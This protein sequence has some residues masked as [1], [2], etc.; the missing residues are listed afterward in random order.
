MV[1]EVISLLLVAVVLVGDAACLGQAQPI[2]LSRK[3]ILLTACWARWSSRCRQHL[4]GGYLLAEHVI[5]CQGVGFDIV[6]KQTPHSGFRGEP[7][8]SG[9]SRVVE[10]PGLA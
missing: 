8:S 4:K 9:A 7:L 2:V 10:E 1:W 3:Q 5:T 6:A